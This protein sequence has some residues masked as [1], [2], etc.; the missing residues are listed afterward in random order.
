MHKLEGPSQESIYIL[1]ISIYVKI[2]S[3]SRLFSYTWLLGI[4]VN[5]L[6]DKKKLNAVETWR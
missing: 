5:S 2:F 4:F 3:S 6:C 1:I